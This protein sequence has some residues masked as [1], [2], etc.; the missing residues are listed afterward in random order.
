MPYTEGYWN[1]ALSQFATTVT[2]PT[3]TQT[4]TIDE[5][6]ETCGFCGHLGL[7]KSSFRCKYCRRWKDGKRPHYKPKKGSV[8]AATA[9]SGS[10]Q[11]V[12]ATDDQNIDHVGTTTIQNISKESL[13]SKPKT[14]VDTG[15]QI[16][17]TAQNRD[18]NNCS[19]VKEN[20]NA[21]DLEHAKAK[22]ADSLVSITQDCS[23]EVVS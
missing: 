17:Q 20:D 10:K 6:L 21:S 15:A 4:K 16:S 22:I 13:P 7:K 14:A 9:D 19:P 2:T 1:S 8:D 18:T 5:P 11:S 23:I 3:K 12:N